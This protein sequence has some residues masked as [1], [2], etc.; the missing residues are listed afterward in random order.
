M[1]LGDMDQAASSVFNSMYSKQAMSSDIVQVAHHAINDI[2]STYAKINARIAIVPQSESNAKARKWS[3][4]ADYA[5]DIYCADV[6][7]YGFIMNADGSIGTERH[8]HVG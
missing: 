3:S 8:A 5:K 6:Y 7:T 2:K 1:Q 4:F